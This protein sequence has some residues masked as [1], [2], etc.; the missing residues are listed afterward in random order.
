VTI[1]PVFI[2][3]E[4]VGKEGGERREGGRGREAGRGRWAGVE[5]W[6]EETRRS[7]GELGF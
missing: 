2:L 1:L 6:I 7:S 3:T 5:G 4:P